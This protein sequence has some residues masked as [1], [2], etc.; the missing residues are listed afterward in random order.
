MSCC[1]SIRIS[2]FRKLNLL[3]S[4]KIYN[5]YAIIGYNDPHKM[6]RWKAMPYK[7]RNSFDASDT[8]LKFSKD[9]TFFTEGICWLTLCCGYS[10]FCCQTFTNDSIDVQEAN[11]QEQISQ[12]RM[13]FIEKLTEKKLVFPFNCQTGEF[14]I[15]DS[16][17]RQFDLKITEDTIKTL[18]EMFPKFDQSEIDIKKNLLYLTC[19]LPY[20]LLGLG[21]C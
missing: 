15:K 17:L 13:K 21:C 2:I 4:I 19:P 5:L 12:A 9:C 20:L 11:F 1:C 14:I 3:K 6:L 18:F 16:D 8:P 7:S 10:W